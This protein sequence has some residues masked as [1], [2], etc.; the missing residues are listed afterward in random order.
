[1]CLYCERKDHPFDPNDTRCPY[2]RPTSNKIRNSR[3]CPKC[4]GS[5][6]LYTTSVNVLA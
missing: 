2:M 3:V 5:G 1:M 6:V 4:R